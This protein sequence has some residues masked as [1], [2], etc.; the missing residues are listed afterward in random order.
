M[1]KPNG[2]LSMPPMEVRR[3]D[4]PTPAPVQSTDSINLVSVARL[5]AQRLRCHDKDLAAIFALNDSLF[6]KSFDPNND[7]HNRPMK[8]TLPKEYAEAFVRTM[9]EMLGLRIG[10]S[11]ARERAFANLVQACADVVKA[12]QL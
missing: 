4:M 9:A 10:G 1:R 3:S 5:A 8:A 2:Q 12:G 6:Y 11:E 7:T